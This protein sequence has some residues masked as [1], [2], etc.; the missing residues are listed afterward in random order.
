[1]EFLD[2]EEERKRLS[3]LM[4]SPEPAFACVYGRRRCGKTRLLLELLKMRGNSTYC[5]ADRIDRQLQINAVAR[6][7][8]RTIPVFK[9]MSFQN[10][11]DL[12]EAWLAFAPDG[13]ILVLDEFPYLAL[14]ADELTSVLQR[15]VDEMT[16]QGRNRKLVICG[17][18]QRM[19]QGFVLQAN[20]PLYGRAREILPIR[21]LPFA[22]LARAF[23]KVPP[24]ERLAW[25]GVMGGVPRYWELAQHHASLREMIVEEIAS[26]LGVL[27]NEPD[28]LLMDDV[29]DSARAA[30]L[31]SVI[32]NGANRVSEIAARLNR[33]ATDLS[34]SLKRLLDLGLI[35]REVPF[36]TDPLNSKK[37][38]YR[39]AD[40]FLAF[41][42]KFILPNRS[43]VDY[44]QRTADWKS[45]Q[46]PF[47]IYLGS[48]WERLVRELLPS[49]GVPGVSER[50]A[51]VSRWWG[52]GTDG[53]PV[54]LDVVAESDDG[55][56]LLVGEA[57][58]T[59][60][61]RERAR[62]LA[63]LENKAQH[64]PFRSKY[65]SLI[66][67]LFVADDFQMSSENESFSKQAFSFSNV[68]SPEAKL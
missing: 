17:S 29:D 38:L 35:V 67:H 32:G 26:P 62:V 25:W 44:L 16:F 27:W 41:W 51:Q 34:H 37:S 39:I 40:N 15:I 46:E 7:L 14:K 19:M 6:T 3:R 12:F 22:C 28:F 63:E 68:Q 8:A 9:P 2:R 36:G 59:L 23:P 5:L 61:K 43:C 13:H 20:E 58:L 64:L 10:W 57:K 50:W 65:K 4:D 11:G 56:T 24:L 31:L 55:Q 18:S 66:T 21:P 45:F 53:K 42:Y 47:R 30:S 52:T 1:M 54:E 49:Q 60:L 33:K 48:V